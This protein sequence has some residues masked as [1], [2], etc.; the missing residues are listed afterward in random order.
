MLVISQFLNKTGS[1]FRMLKLL[2]SEGKVLEASYLPENKNK[3]NPTLAWWPPQIVLWKNFEYQLKEWKHVLKLK[4]CSLAVLL[5]LQFVEFDE[6]SCTLLN[7]EAQKQN[8]PH[9]FLKCWGDP[10]NAGAA[11]YLGVVSDPPDVGDRSHLVG[12]QNSSQV[13]FLVPHCH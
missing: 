6:N 5:S 3:K 7:V 8:L 1:A 11:V 13:H 9:S 4:L 2:L 12:P 10:G